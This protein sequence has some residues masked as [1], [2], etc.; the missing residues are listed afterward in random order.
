MTTVRR[1][2]AISFIERYALIALSLASNILIA[3]LL[4]PKEIGLYSVSLAAIGIAQVL[5]D[6]GVGG[7]LIQEK[8]LTE[9][10]IRSAFGISLLMGS[11]LFILVFF[12]S[13]WVGLLYEE[14]HMVGTLRISSL[15]FLVLPFCTV[16]LALLRREMQF[17]KILYV[18]LIATSIGFTVTIALAYAGYGANSMA[19]GA[20]VTNLVTGF[21]AWVAR[22]TQKVTL[23]SLLEWRKVA[24]FGAQRSAS[25]IAG[26]MSSDISE[27]V[28]GKLLGFAPVAMLSRAQGLMNLFQRDLMT[29]ITSVAYPA[30]AKDSRENNNVEVKHVAAVAAITVVGWPFFGFVAL[31]G[32]E[33]LRLLFG[34]QWD[35]AAAFVPWYCLAGVVAAPSYLIVPLL[36]AIGRIDSATKI[37]LIVQ[38]LR[39][40]LFIFGLA[41]FPSIDTPPVLFLIAASCATPFGYYMKGKALSNDMPNLLTGLAKSAAVT[42]VSL[43]LP[44]ATILTVGRENG[45]LELSW[46]FA[47]AFSCAVSWVVAIYVIRHPMKHDPLFKVALQRFESAFRMIMK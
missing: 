17:Q 4:S 15:N 28:A 27:L 35:E 12:A 41:L 1:A 31:F 25:G 20:V 14:P 40:A 34:R 21:G 6:F 26:T 5:R 24:S 22:G 36:T 42:A 18:T 19:L 7:Y 16:S 47:A 10:H 44:V 32:L 46:V 3:R 37:D 8:N 9:A 23:P 43:I 13:N 45:P 11:V 29:A 33:I 2:L 39:A 38:P 30:F